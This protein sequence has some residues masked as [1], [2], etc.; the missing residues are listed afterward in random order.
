VGKLDGNEMTAL[1]IEGLPLHRERMV[2]PLEQIH[3]ANPPGSRE[4]GPVIDLKRPRPVLN[5][6]PLEIPTGWFE[7]WRLPITLD[8]PALPF[9]IEVNGF[10]PY[11]RGMQTVMVDGQRRLRPVVEPVSSRMSSIVA[12]SASAIRLTVTPRNAVA[13]PYTNWIVF[14]RFPHRVPDARPLDVPLGPELGTWRII[15]SLREES[16][17]AVLAPKQLDVT[18]FPGMRGIESYRT[19]AIAKRPGMPPREVGV[20]TNNTH[21]V[22]RWTLYQSGAAQD[23]WSFTILGVGNRNGIHLMNIGWIVVTL[24]AIYAFYVKPV[25]IRRMKDMPQNRPEGRA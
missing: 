15:Y 6:G 25:L 21:T 18:Y 1:E 22:G 11:I 9:T 14:S 20:S 3:E 13:E 12:Y 4:L 8:D 10:M 16:L 5:V 7:R 19:E 23:G 24:G 2:P 17:E